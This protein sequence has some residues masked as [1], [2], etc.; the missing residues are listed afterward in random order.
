MKKR[1]VDPNFTQMSFF[2]MAGDDF[3]NDSVIENPIVPIR[4]EWSLQLFSL[5]NIQE[6]MPQ[7]KM[8]QDEDVLKAE[9]RFFKDMGKGILFTNGTGTGK[10]QP[11]YSKILTPDGWKSMRDIK[12]GDKV[13]AASGLPT[14]VIGIFPQ[15]FKDIYEVTFSDGTTTRCCKEH[16]WETQTL[17]E[18]RNQN[19]LESRPLSSKK[20]NKDLNRWKPKV[21]SLEEIISS[22]DERHFIPVVK[23]IEFPEKEVLIPFYT[24]GYIIGDGHMK[25]LVSVSSADPESLIR[26]SKELPLDL[27][28]RKIQNTKYDYKISNGNN[29]GKDGCFLPNPIK[30]ELDRLGILGKL[31]YDKFIPKDYLF[32]SI[33]QRIAL[34]QGLLDSDGWVCKKTNS[35]YFSTSSERLA[36]DFSDLVMSLGGVARKSIKHPTFTYKG[37]KKKGAPSYVI[38]VN[39]PEGIEP[40]FLSRKSILY[41]ANYKYLPKKV[42]EKIEF[43]GNEP[44]QCISIEDDRHLYV[45]DGFNL[46]HNTYTGLGIAKR[47]IAMDKK[48]IL[49]ISPTDK[50][51]KDWIEEAEYMG[52]AVYQLED[53]NDAKHS[54]CVTTYS[55]FYQNEAISRIHWH[56]VIYDES[57]YLQQN[58]QGETTVY[59]LRH[60]QIARLPSVKKAEL[61]LPEN[62][63]YVNSKTDEELNQILYDYAQSTKVVFLSATPFA[64][65]KSLMLADGCLWDIE[66]SCVFREN[67]HWNAKPKK[68][69]FYIENFGYRVRYN[70]L[71]IPETGV[72]MNLMEREFYEKYKKLG[73]ISGRTID[74]PFDYSRDFIVLNSEIGRKIDEGMEIFT[75]KYFSDNYKTLKIFYKRK[76]NSMYKR[77]LLESIKSRLVIPRIKEHVNMGRKVV[78]FHDFN[79]AQPSHPFKFELEEMLKPGSE[80]WFLNVR[81]LSEDIDRFNQEYAEYVDMDLSELHNPIDSVL[82]EF[83]EDEVAIYNGTI[84]KGKRHKL[85]ADFMDDNSVRNIFIGQRKACKEGVSLHDMTGKKERVFIDLGLPTMPTDAIQ[86]EGRIYRIGLMSNARYEYQTIQTNFEMNAFA[87]TISKRSRTA[88]NL[89]LGNLARNMEIV[90][91]EGYSSADWIPVEEITGTGGKES[92]RNF[93]EIS[94]FDKAKTYYWSNL[95]KTSKTKAEEGID[96]FAT[97]EPLG[98]KM[99]EWLGLKSDMRVL[100]PSAGH[101]AIARFLPGFTNNVMIEPSYRLAAKLK[102]SSVGDVYEIPF[103]QYSIINKFERI[104]MNPPFGSGGKLAAE[105]L[106]KALTNHLRYRTDEESVLMAIIPDGSSMTKRLNELMDR[107][108]VARMFYLSHEILL[109]SCTFERAGT[110]VYCKIIVIK[111]LKYLENPKPPILIDLSKI[112]TINEFFD[113]IETLE[114]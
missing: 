54:V 70:K 12:I 63:D 53:I 39:L 111:T 105:H 10:A 84:S 108:E 55:N 11:L 16:L 87:E 58:G 21:R 15:G 31:S 67:R 82:D 6:Q 107:R 4:K 48:H 51:C 91:K 71:T 38:S 49:I 85:Y 98:F 76:Y 62:F 9:K 97:P 23:P 42:I 73:V 41:K 43:I 89:A 27:T 47:F 66:E 8:G 24:M 90:F 56:L 14:K 50:K 99:V 2:D 112:Q 1:A 5:E 78:L 86:G 25:S 35:P 44:T 106:E 74:V 100:E 52:I 61:N 93:N 32:G 40:F 75:Q 34:L 102:I 80:E 30:T 94:E 19:N 64:Y 109:P 69:E 37:E 3:W 88:E 33:E 96:Y 46:T 28:M 45:T 114:I 17:R 60:K 36:N 65:V 104:V 68:W 92:D 110:K 59:E 95:K 7:L 113:E 81:G 26:I 101:G 18:R 57:H 13:I 20:V 22:I 77:Q 103:E 83:P 72:D 29:I 79:R